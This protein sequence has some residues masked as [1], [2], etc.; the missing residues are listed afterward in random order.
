MFGSDYPHPEGLAEPAGFVKE[1]ETLPVETTRKIM[2][3]NL[4]T[5][6]GV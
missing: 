3:S 1:L 2:G 4:K 6:I 5:L